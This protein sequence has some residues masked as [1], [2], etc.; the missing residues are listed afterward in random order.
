MRDEI[1]TKPIKIGRQ[2]EIKREYMIRVR[3]N[4]ENDMR[5]RNNKVAA[6]SI[7]NKYI[8]ERLGK[9]TICPFKRTAAIYSPCVSKQ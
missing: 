1:I 9:Q 8:N 4:Y 7:K 6:K 3:K 2:N 5:E